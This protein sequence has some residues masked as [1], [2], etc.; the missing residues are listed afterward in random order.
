MAGTLTGVTYDRPLQLREL[1]RDLVHAACLRGEFLLSGGTRSTYYFDKYLFVTRPSILRRLGR[2]LA[3]LVP[4]DTDRIAVSELGAVPLG[5]AVSMEVGLPFVI[6]K[7]ESAPRPVEGE[8]H[9]GERVVVVEDVVNT[10][11]QALRAVRRLGD[12]GAVVTAVVAVIDRE[13]GGEQRM[14]SAGLRY[15]P[16]FRKTELPL[17]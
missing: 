16:L 3:E 1:A 9:R 6:V 13:E 8:L 7:E 2:F 4:L 10:G 15:L 17:D 11:S 14:N 5:A 12:A